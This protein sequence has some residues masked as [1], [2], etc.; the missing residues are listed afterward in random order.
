MTFH[1]AGEL[2]NVMFRC[3]VS[4]YMKRTLFFTF[5]EK[6]QIVQFSTTWHQW[7]YSRPTIQMERHKNTH[8]ASQI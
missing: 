1:H 8:M 5:G 6:H 2:K 4:S 3:F 7:N